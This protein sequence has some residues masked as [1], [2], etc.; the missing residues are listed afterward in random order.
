M[1]P[2]VVPNMPHHVAQ[3]QKAQ[4][5]TSSLV[6]SGQPPNPAVRYQTATGLVGVAITRSASR[7]MAPAS[8]SVCESRASL[9]LC[10]RMR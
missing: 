3:V 7:C 4:A 1:N 2:L 9:E 5:K 10:A 8:S 6:D